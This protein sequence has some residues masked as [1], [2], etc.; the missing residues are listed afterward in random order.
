MVRLQGLLSRLRVCEKNQLNF[1]NLLQG[2][3]FFL[4]FQTQRRPSG[5]G[6]LLIAPTYWEGLVCVTVVWLKVPI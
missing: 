4:F 3:N 6:R 2:F 5:S 1:D